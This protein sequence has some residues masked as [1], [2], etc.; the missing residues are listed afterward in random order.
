M[1]AHPRRAVLPCV[2]QDIAADVAMS[3]GNSLLPKVP[4]LG[5]VFRVESPSVVEAEML[6]E[7]VTDGRCALAG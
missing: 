5:D 4:Q 1:A 7:I 3:F 2:G 6:K